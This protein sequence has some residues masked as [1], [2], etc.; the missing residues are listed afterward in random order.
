VKENEYGVPL[1][2]A[3]TLALIGDAKKM[4]SKFVKGAYFKNYGVTLFVGVGV[5]IPILNEEIAY[6][7]SLSNEELHTEIKDYSKLERPTV[8]V[9]SYAQLKSGKVEINGK[10]VRTTSLSSLEKAR[11]IAHTLKKWIL[12][13]NF[14]LTNPSAILDEERTLKNLSKVEQIVSHLENEKVEYVMGVLNPKDKL[15]EHKECVNC[16]ACVSVC[17]YEALYWEKDKVKFDESKCVY[18]MLCTDTCPVG[19]K[20]PDEKSETKFE[21]PY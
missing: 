4:D 13:G 19:L 1:V 21:M 2:P 6:Y 11:E 5:P 9:V 15:N 8:G 17:N 18:C 20:L 12:A 7:V 3:R 16:G 14:F 10:D